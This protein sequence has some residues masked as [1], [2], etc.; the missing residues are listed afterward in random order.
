MGE[1]HT[2]VRDIIGDAGDPTVLEYLVSCLELE[3]ETAKDA[4]QMY[5]NY[6]DMLVRS[7]SPPMIAERPAPTTSSAHACMHA[8][9]TNAAYSLL[10]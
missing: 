4:T 3:D 5:S 2:A 7:A 9:R 10:I 8:C 1:V 6:G